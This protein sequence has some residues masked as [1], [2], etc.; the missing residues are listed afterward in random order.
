MNKISFKTLGY[1]IGFTIIF[2]SVYLYMTMYGIGFGE[3]IFILIGI[4]LSRKFLENASNSFAKT[5]KKRF[6]M[7]YEQIYIQ[8]LEFSFQ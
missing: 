1:Y 2:E 3:K 6:L 7:E 4:A 5:L 8:M